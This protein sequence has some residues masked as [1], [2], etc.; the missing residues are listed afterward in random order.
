[1]NVPYGAIGFELRR[2]AVVRKKVQGERAEHAQIVRTQPVL[3]GRLG[4]VPDRDH[5]IVTV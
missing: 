1:M 5:A 2:R 3:G 4:T